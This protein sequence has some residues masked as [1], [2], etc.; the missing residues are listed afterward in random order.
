MDVH[1]EEIRQLLGKI[2]DMTEELWIER[3][4]LRMMLKTLGYSDE[5]LNQSQQSAKADPVLREEARQACSQMREALDET[6][7]QA[8]I[9]ELSQNPPPKGEAN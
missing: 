9:E 7:I 3:E 6:G 1:L 2:A 4:T 8:L 5:V